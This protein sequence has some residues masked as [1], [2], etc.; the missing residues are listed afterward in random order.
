MGKGFDLHGMRSIKERELP[1]VHRLLERCIA[2]ARAHHAFPTVTI[3]SGIIAEIKKGSPSLGGISEVKPAGQAARYCRGGACALSVLTDGNF[4]G[5]SWADLWSVADSTDLPL[6][7]KEF[8]FF[9]EQIDLAECLGADMVLLIARALE[10]ARL[11]A[12]YGRALKLSL[13][14][15]VEVHA[16]TELPGVLDL[17]PACV[18][19][20][21]RNL[22]T[23]AR[24]DDVAA[25]AFAKLPEGIRG[26]WAS[27]MGSAEEIAAVRERTGARFFLVGTSLMKSGDPEKLLEEMARVC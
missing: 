8:I 4:F 3:E 2:R 23:L 5:G 18:L 24:E 17:G 1:E 9:E 16:E 27:G 21:S 13:L 22:E 11:R 12:L 10:P 25:R 19:V 20:N 26:V 15:L 7:C 14:P 6:L